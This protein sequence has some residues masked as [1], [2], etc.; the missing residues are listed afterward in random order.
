MA[1]RLLHPGADTKAI[2][3]VY[4]SMIRSLRVLDPQG[5]LLSRVAGPVRRYLRCV[6]FDQKLS[7]KDANASRNWVHRS[8]DD[9]IRC[10]VALLTDKESDLFEELSVKID[11]PQVQDSKDAAEDYNDPKWMPDPTDAPIG[12]CLL[13]M[14]WQA[15]NIRSTIVEQISGKVKAAISFRAW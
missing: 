6:E 8:R 3:D 14:I 4:I 9:T 15:A 7:T 10:V 11:A 2:I 12:A 1:K 13:I 5:V